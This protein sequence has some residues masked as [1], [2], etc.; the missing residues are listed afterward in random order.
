MNSSH[1]SNLQKNEKRSLVGFLGVPT[2]IGLLAF[3]F[4]PRSRPDIQ[5]QE[6]SA[7]LEDAEVSA[8]GE[9]IWDVSQIGS[10][11]ERFPNQEIN[12]SAKYNL[13]LEFNDTIGSLFRGDPNI[14]DVI[15]LINTLEQTL[16]EGEYKQDSFELTRIPP[17]NQLSAFGTL[18][19][20]GVDFI[21]S[22]LLSCQNIGDTL[23]NRTTI[24]I[25]TSSPDNNYQY[26]TSLAF[27]QSNELTVKVEKRDNSGEKSVLLDGVLFRITTGG[28]FVAHLE[29]TNINQVTYKPEFYAP[30]IVLAE[31]FFSSWNEMGH[32]LI[33]TVKLST[34]PN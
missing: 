1:S 17:S 29:R 16:E 8:N 14:Q 6:P 33:Q 27:D 28:V 5:S 31:S 4:W 34:I 3:A 18:Q 23:L 25:K 7:P 9:S 26:A 13:N 30:P 24:N 15:E 19:L 10:L 22:A 12:R 20:T 11:P 32:K 21:E 2:C